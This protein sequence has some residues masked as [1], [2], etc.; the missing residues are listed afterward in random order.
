MLWAVCCIAFIGFLRIGEM[1]VPSN[2]A[3]DPSVHLSL[4]DIAVDNL[5]RH[6]VLRLTIKQSKTDLFWKGVDLF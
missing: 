3:Y 5:E 6:T 1:V 4:T 2:S